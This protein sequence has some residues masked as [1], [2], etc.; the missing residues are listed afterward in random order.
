MKEQNTICM[1][2]SARGR[3]Y[4]RDSRLFGRPWHCISGA[5]RRR[6]V[7]S[8]SAIY[9]IPCLIVM[10]VR[11]RDKSDKWFLSILLFDFTM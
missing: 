9:L 6:Y 3:K 10:R 2:A 1:S 5:S 7:P 8:A 4:W 11:F